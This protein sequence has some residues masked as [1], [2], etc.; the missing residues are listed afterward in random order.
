MYKDPFEEY[1]RAQEPNRKQLSYAWQTA[2]GL[3]KVDDLEPSRYLIK[4]AKK[5]I[6]GEIKTLRAENKT[7]QIENK[8]L[9]SSF[10]M[11]IC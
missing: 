11:P 6:E 9:K 7:L 10:P 4:T 3:Q 2:V 1:L 5:S 8:T